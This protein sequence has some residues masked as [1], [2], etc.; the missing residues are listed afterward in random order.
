M[1]VR[2]T[3]K[4]E[5]RSRLFLAISLALFFFD[6]DVPIEETSRCK[7]WLGDYRQKTV[8]YESAMNFSGT[9]YILYKRLQDTG[10]QE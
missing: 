8:Y 1:C 5:F 7:N 9:L 3:Y 4:Q 10:E 2:F 6:P